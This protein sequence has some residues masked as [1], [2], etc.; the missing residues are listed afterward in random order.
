MNLRTFFALLSGGQ[1]KVLGTL[2]KV[3]RDYHRVAF[4]AAGLSSGW[5]QR[6]TSGP[7]AFDTLV[8]GLKID[9]AMHD[10]LKSW[11]RI[12]VALGELSLKPEGY[13]ANG[14]ISR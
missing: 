5:L 7:V 13:V 4:L 12:G 3:A 10:G 1:L 8:A 9:R 14:K 6:L 11:L 2:G